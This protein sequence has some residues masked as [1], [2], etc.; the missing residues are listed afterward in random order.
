MSTANALSPA[1]LRGE[2]R[3]PDDDPTRPLP[4]HT[5]LPDSDGAIVTNYQEHP[6]GVL[7]TATLEPYFQRRHPNN[8]YCVGQDSGIY[9][10]LTEPPLN[11]AIAPDWCYIS[12][13]PAML[14]GKL[15]RSYVLW[16]EHIPPAIVLEFVSG[17]GSEERN[18]TPEKGK[19]W[20]YEN[21]VGA[22]YYGIYEVDPGRI[23]MYRLV[24]GRYE[25]QRLN[26]S[27]RFAIEPMGLEL[28]IWRGTYQGLHFPW[29]R[30]WDADGVMIPTGHELATMEHRRAETERRLASA[31]RRRAELQQH[32]AESEKQ[33][34]ESEKQRAESEMQR[35][36]SEKQRAELEQQRAESEKQRAETA[37][38][39]AESEKQRAER[40]AAQL[41]ALGIDPEA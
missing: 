30:W 2:F 24:N 17:D 28:G 29:M 38:Q 34:A 16:K 33:R 19:F 40:L 41:R 23:E 12:G 37:Q 15:R 10:K 35:A 26:A 22:E 5:Q 13:V 18:R 32:R 36:E 9:W 4:D 7:L 25:L 8:D 39:R 1:E 27:G 14:Q 6:Q 21:A 20:I 11:G 3:P 31:E